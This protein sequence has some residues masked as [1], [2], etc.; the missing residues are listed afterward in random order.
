MLVNQMQRDLASSSILEI[1][2]SL[3]AVTNI[4]TSDM[5]PAMQG[6]VVKMLDHSSELVRKKAI[7]AMHRFHQLAPEAVEKQD[8]VDKLRKMLCDRDP[9]VMGSSLNVIESLATV[10]P[11]PFKELVSSLI[12][13]LKQVIEHRLPSDFEY[14]RVPAPWIQMKI[15]RILAALGKNDANSS[16]GMYEIL[17]ETMKKADVG[18]NAGYAVVYECVRT[19]TAIYPNST[20][21]DAAADAIS[22]F[23]QSKSQN[24]KY[25]GV[26][27]LAA[28]VESHPQYA[29]AHQMSVIECLEDRDETLQRR[30]LDLLYKMTNPMNVQFIT[31][32]LLHFLKGTTDSFLKK[33][34]TIKVCRLAERYAPNNLWFVETITELFEISGEF[35]SQEV[36]QQLMTLIAEGAGE[37]DDE[38]ADTILRQHSVA[39][40]ANLL[41]KPISKLPQLLIETMAWVLGEYAYLSADY[42]LEEILSKLCELVR[43][44][45]QLGGSTRKIVVT[46]VMKLVAQA[47]TCPPQA[48]K[49]IDDFAKS[50]DEDLQQR[51]IEFQNLIT[52]A[53][54]LLGEVLPVDASCEDVQ[55]DPNLS[56]MDAYVRQAV[57]N[58]A[59]QYDKPEDDDDDDNITSTAKVSAFKYTTYDKPSKPGASYNSSS[60]G[61]VG[62]NTPQMSSGGAGFGTTLPPGSYGH[63]QNN[64]SSNNG[65]S[66]TGSGE[67]QLNVRNVANVWGKKSLSGGP[68]PAAPVPPTSFSAPT[69]APAPT[70]TWSTSSAYS[71]QSAP[72]PPPEPVKTEE[73]LRKERMAAALFG[74]AP[75]A[76]TP[77]R[78]AVPK[79]TA[80]RP[81]ISSSVPVPPAPAPPPPPAPEMDLLDFMD[82]PVPS[83]SG[84]EAVSAPDVDILAPS[85]IEFTPLPAEDPAPPPAEVFPEDPFAASGLLDGMMDAPLSSFPSNNHFQHNGQTLAPLTITTAQFGEKWGTCPHASPISATSLKITTLDAFMVLCKSVGLHNIES[86][87]STNEGICGGMVAGT[88]L[89]LVHGKVSSSGASA[90]ID[91]TI[92]STD[93][94]LGGCLGM[95]MQNLLR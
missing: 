31:E 65:N 74:G 10:D 38:D 24:L 40:Y 83:T 51:C 41:E 26:T 14:H 28:I 49:I 80:P 5:V 6:L 54:H 60:M 46:A 4:I 86:I 79:R 94:S 82:D 16:N 17:G 3:I 30:T 52:T 66:A 13:I 69:P 18:I 84:A 53:P 88:E 20:L 67:P 36:S 27:G 93:S 55:V 72:Q 73:Q 7:I 77:T 92:K 8:L 68:A 70:N 9:G 89:V 58:G 21:L 48:A 37:E 35:V 32:K 87:L 95:Y 59:K 42:T 56:F 25:F 50:K 29:A 61:G 75:P 22:R 81:P 15:V 33:D 45:K 76:A 11:K 47:G 91:V 39:I 62:S 23:I 71:T 44:G 2:G 78:P 19:I 57:A 63:T 12:S 1:C 34:L 90:K 43:K 85:P 64:G